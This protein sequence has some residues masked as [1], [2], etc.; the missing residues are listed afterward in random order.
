[1][2]VSQVTSLM[3]AKSGQERRLTIVTAKHFDDLDETKE[4]DYND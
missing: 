4:E 2:F 1:M 3:A